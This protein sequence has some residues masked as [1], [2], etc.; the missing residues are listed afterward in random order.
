MGAGPWGL[1]VDLREDPKASRPSLRSWGRTLER[2]GAAR[3]V[4]AIKALNSCERRPHRD[5]PASGPD[6]R[7]RGGEVGGGDQGFGAVDALGCLRLLPRPCLHIRQS[8]LDTRQSRPD[9]RQSRSDLRQSRPD[10]K[11]PRP[12]I[13]DSQGHMAHIRQS[14]PDSGLGFQVKSPLHL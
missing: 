8:G 3:L 2:F 6:L 5:R 12:R 1:G 7:G 11:Q 13:S 10:M 4:E 9:V 14:R